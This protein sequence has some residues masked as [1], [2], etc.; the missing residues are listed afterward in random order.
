MSFLCEAF[1]LIEPRPELANHLRDRVEPGF[2]DVLLEPQLYRREE[3]SRTVWFEGQR[4]AQA[5]L[6]FLTSLR[7]YTPVA[8]DTGFA[9]V[10]GSR[11]ISVGL[12]DRWFVIRRFQVDQEL[13][14]LTPRLREHLDQIEPPCIPLVDQWL[15]DLR[16]SASP[17]DP[18]DGRDV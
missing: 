2:A 13:D 15:T 8:D 14:L 6:L 5:K 4:L 10:F 9:A 16:D 7:E 12:F 1:Y 11:A 18:P 3:C 17:A